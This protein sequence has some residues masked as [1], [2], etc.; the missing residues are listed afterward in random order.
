VIGARSSVFTDMPP[1]QVCW[2]SP[3]SPQYARLKN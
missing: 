3:C 2:G 1:G